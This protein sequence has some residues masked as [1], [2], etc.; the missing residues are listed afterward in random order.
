MLLFYIISKIKLIIG[1]NLLVSLSA[2]YIRT[3]LKSQKPVL[4]GD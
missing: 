1:V 2:D 4:S 3:E